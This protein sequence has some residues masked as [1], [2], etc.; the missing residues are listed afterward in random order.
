MCVR[1]RGV[2]RESLTILLQSATVNG[3]GQ[4]IKYH[5]VL[6]VQHE[7]DMRTASRAPQ[8]SNTAVATPEPQGTAA[9]RWLHRFCLV[10]A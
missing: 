5:Y 9:V 3:K 2:C 10:V 4:N 8:P 1:L 6:D 7:S